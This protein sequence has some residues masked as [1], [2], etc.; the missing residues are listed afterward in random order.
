METRHF[1]VKV[2]KQS[3]MLGANGNRIS[4]NEMMMI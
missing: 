1:L 4:E 3:Y 2:I